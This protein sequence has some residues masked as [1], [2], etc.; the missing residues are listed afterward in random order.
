[1][2]KI[3]CSILLTTGLAAVAPADI[4]IE[5]KSESYFYG[6]GEDGLDYPSDYLPA[7]ALHVLIWSPTA[8]PEINYALPGSG[9]GS[10]EHVLYSSN[11]AALRPND[12]RNDSGRFNY[13]I[14]PL[15]FTDADVGDVDIN[16]GYVYSRIFST[17]APGVGSWYYQTQVVQGPALA[18][19][20]ALSPDSIFN[21]TTSS[22]AE[23]PSRGMGI[24]SGMYQVIPEPATGVLALTALGMMIYRRT[25]KPTP[26]GAC[27]G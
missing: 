20:N 2:K 8:P 5:Y 16:T 9:V 1:M 17:S 18:E 22:S 10:G 15:I 26:T 7:D 13:T 24:G 14:D 19:Y 25:R 6:F 11:V 4:A 12:M 21:H 3:L 27:Q 23:A